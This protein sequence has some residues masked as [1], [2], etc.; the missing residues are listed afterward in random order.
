MPVRYDPYD[1][2][3]AYAYVGNRWVA[4]YSEHFSSFR[5]RSERE[6]MIAAAELHKRYRDHSRQ[7]K[8]RPVDSPTLSPPSNRKSRFLFSVS[9]MRPPGESTSTATSPAIAVRTVPRVRARANHNRSLS[10]P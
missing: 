7:L 9:R 10:W 6:M 8:S 3:T 5:G 2:G 1:A 4:C